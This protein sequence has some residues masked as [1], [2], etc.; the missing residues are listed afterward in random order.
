MAPPETVE[1]H[2]LAQQQ[3]A[4]ATLIMAQRQWRLMT[5]DLDGSWSRIVS[6][7]T[8]AVASAQL[9]AARAGA[10]YVPA[11]LGAIGQDVPAVAQVRPEGFAGLASDGRPLDSLLYSA[12]VRTK[13]SLGTGAAMPDAL[14]AGG[15]WL[16]TL[17]KTQVAD[18][19]RGAAGVAIAARPKVGWTRLVGVPCC[20]R[21]AVLAGKWFRYNEGFQR[22]PKCDC[23]HV[24]CGQ[25]GFEGFTSQPTAE[26]VHDLTAAQR[27]AIGDGAD[28]GQVINAHRKGAR[29]K[30]GMTTTEGTTRRGY[31]SH[32]KREVAR[33]RGEMAQEKVVGAARGRRNVTRT[34]PRLTPEAIY[35]V[36]A[37]REEAIA[38]LAK[39]GYIVGNI[40]NVARSVT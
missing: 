32:V 4:E 23:R 28:M 37:T 16:D 39:N 35:R 8:L 30:D 38:L 5:P 17:V 22:H 3:Q 19:G 18:A 13:L 27:R 11:T 1:A 26:Q 36:A 7:L 12:V 33:Q 25:E 2:Y 29:S 9:G 10:A 14:E 21:C 31:A 34:Q 40:T 6:R 15:K 20:Q 24:P